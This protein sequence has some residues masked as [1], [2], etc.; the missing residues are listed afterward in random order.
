ML[1]PPCY[2]K[3]KSQRSDSEISLHY[4]YK[5]IQTTLY[6]FTLLHVQD[7]LGKAA[8]SQIRLVAH[9]ENYYNRIRIRFPAIF[10]LN[11]AS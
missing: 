6:I 10:Y 11:K 8:D 5:H 2:I 1:L 7:K 3:T 4:N 9:T